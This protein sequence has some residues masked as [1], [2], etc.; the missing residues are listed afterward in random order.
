MV[1]ALLV[2]L[3]I[4]VDVLLSVVLR[5]KAMLITMLQR[6]AKYRALLSSM[7]RAL[8]AHHLMLV[9]VLLLLVTPTSS[10]ATQ[11][12]LMG[13]SRPS[14]ATQS[15]LPT[16]R[17]LLAHLPPPALLL[18]ALQAKEML[19]TMPLMAVKFHVAPSPM[20]LAPHVPLRLPVTVQL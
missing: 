13:V 4:P 2:P 10:T 1:L 20:V 11:I 12:Q 3:L 5:A 19:T 8:H 18:L 6:V 14:T 17:A 9:D 15:L 16:L 7:E